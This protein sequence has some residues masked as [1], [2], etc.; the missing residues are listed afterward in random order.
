M[1]VLLKHPAP[2][3]FEKRSKTMK[4]M[5]E[6]IGTR[7]V[8]DWWNTVALGV[9]A[10][11]A[12]LVIGFA[13]CS[14]VS[15]NAGTT[16]KG[17]ASTTTTQGTTPASSTAIA[18][19]STVPTSLANTGEYG[20]NVYDYA[21]A[22]DWKNAD[23]KLA[24]LREAIKSVR[25][26]VKNKS[27]AVDRLDEHVAALDRFVAAKD[28]HLVMREANQVTIDAAEMSRT[29]KLSVPVEVT[30]L[31]YYGRELEVWAQVQDA[32]SLATTVREL[33]QTWEAV[34]P[35][36]EAHSSTEAKRFDALVAQVEASKTPAHYAR[37]A[38]PVLNEV[39]NLEKLFH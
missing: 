9:V 18:T 1:P 8:R 35:T 23:V 6:V 14:S 20:E 33:R 2:A 28:K 25:T 5:N 37:V 4:T 12:F 24:A 11:I 31:D 16:N 36:I 29:Y 13:A 10:V 3:G 15:R 19:E 38:T 39:D 26:D 30:K 22:N 34:R 17:T 21:K 27:A 32:N 7:E